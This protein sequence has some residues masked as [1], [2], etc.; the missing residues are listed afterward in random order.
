MLVYDLVCDHNHRF[1]GWFQSLEDYRRQQSRGLLSCPVC[2]SAEVSRIPSASH[3]HT[4]KGESRSQPGAEQQAL[5]Q[6]LRQMRDYIQHHS[7]H[8]GERFA[9]EARKIH[10]GEAEV[11]NIHGTASRDEVVALREEGIQAVPL[12][13][14]VADKTKLN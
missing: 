4:G 8:V 6:W 2:D 12:P 10:Y 13:A 1:E 7:E 3:V 14:L 9:E 11:R 5:G